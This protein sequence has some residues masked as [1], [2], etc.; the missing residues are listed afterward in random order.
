[1]PPISGVLDPRS[2]QERFNLRD[3]GCIGCS[4]DQRSRWSTSAAR[5][6]SPE[7]ETLPE[8]SLTADVAYRRRR[9]PQ[10]SL[11]ADVA[12]RRPRLPETSLT[13]DLEA[14]TGAPGARTTTRHRYRTSG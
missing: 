13:G 12:H 7:S 4:N 3:C 11:T 6:R 8:T 1:M 14:P 9:L 5:S 10:T 2:V